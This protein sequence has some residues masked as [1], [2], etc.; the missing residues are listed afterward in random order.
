MDFKR[1]RIEANDL[2]A[3][4]TLGSLPIG[5][6]NIREQLIA[7]VEPVDASVTPSSSQTSAIPAIQWGGENLSLITK[8]IHIFVF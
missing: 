3:I 8:A 1:Y 7:R 2:K 6:F 5:V 4:Q